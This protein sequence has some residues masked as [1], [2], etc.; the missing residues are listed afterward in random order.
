MQAVFSCSVIL[1]NKGGNGDAH[2]TEYHPGQRINF[3]KS[4]PGGHT[5]GSKA[6]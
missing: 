2:G 1:P 6:V 3:S 5:V 4:G